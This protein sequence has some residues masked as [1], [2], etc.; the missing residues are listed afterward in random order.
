MAVSRGLLMFMRLAMLFQ[1]AI[2]IGL[3]TGHLYSLVN[4]HRTVGVLFV[5]ALWVIAVLAMVYRRAIGLAAFALAWGVLVA[6]FGFMQQAIL[7]G[8]YHWIIR[9]LHI[10]IGFAAMPIAERLVAEPGR[11]PASPNEPGRILSR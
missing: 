6:G 10:V 9:V 1:L 2:G 7:P 3:W 4:V 5:L 11:A 8:D